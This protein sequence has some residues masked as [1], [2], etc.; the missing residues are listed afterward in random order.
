MISS[1]HDGDR[2]SK[3]NPVVQ[4]QQQQQLEHLGTVSKNKGHLMGRQHMVFIDKWSLFG[5]YFVLCYKE[6]L[7]KCGL[8]LQGGLYWEMAFNTGVTVLHI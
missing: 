2:H 6:G 5:G 8:Y 1:I 3:V 4:Q 7:L